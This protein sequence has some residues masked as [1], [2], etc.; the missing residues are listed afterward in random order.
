MSNDDAL[1]LAR[2]SAE[3]MYQDDRASQSLGMTM[4]IP[5]PGSATTSMTVTESMVN[6]HDL[7]HGGFIFSL[8]DS[9]FAFACNAYGRVTV[10]AG[11]SIHFLRA[12]RLGDQLTATAVEVERP[13]RTG[14]Y[15]VRVTNQRGE[16]VA[17]FQGRSA[18]LGPDPK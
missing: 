8:A 18:E 14:F 12:A 4:E 9:A 5:A 13:G 10:A 6:G 1:A 7:C 15:D 2:S 11:A 3:R 17:L 16:L